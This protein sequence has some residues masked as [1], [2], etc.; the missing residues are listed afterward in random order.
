LQV[1]LSNR[2]GIETFN[3]RNLVPGSAVHALGEPVNH[4]GTRFTPALSQ[5]VL[6]F[7]ADDF[8]CQFNLPVPNHIKIDVDGIEFAILKGMDK[9]LDD[10]SLE[11]LLVEVNEERGERDQVLGFLHE[12]GFKVH[13]RHGANYIFVRET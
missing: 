1:A 3:Y 12:K 13:S 5:P 10:L 11:S 6:S 8:I 4:L 9:T 7:R 2:T